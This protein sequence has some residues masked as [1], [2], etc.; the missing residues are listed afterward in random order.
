MAG[1][2]SCLQPG[3]HQSRISQPQRAASEQFST[4]NKL[5]TKCRLNLTADYRRFDDLAI[6][7]E[8]LQGCTILPQVDLL[9]LQN[10]SLLS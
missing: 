6:Y 10:C 8:K 5:I 7:A 3:D 4:L 2:K 9:S 1:D